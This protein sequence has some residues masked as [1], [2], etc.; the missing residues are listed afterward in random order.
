MTT[1][2]ASRTSRLC[3][4]AFKWFK[5]QAAAGLLSVKLSGEPVAA[6]RPRVGRFGTYYSSRYDKYRKVALEEAN[7]VLETLPTD[8]PVIVFME[9]VIEKPRTGKLEFP[10]ADIDNYA[11]GP[12]DVLTKT[13]KVWTDDSQIVALFAFKRYAEKGE[14]PGVIVSW[15]EH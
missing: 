12:L 8:K 14:D 9:F 7:S 13:Q 15:A 4:A 1:K 2:T 5:S 11:K 6:S 10:R 3:Q